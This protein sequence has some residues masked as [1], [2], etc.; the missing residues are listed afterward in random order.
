MIQPE[1]LFPLQTPPD[2]LEQT[3]ARRHFRLLTKLA[4]QEG[5]NPPGAALSGNEDGSVDVNVV[6]PGDGFILEWGID[7]W[8][9]EHRLNRDG[10]LV[11]VSLAFGGDMLQVIWTAEGGWEAVLKTSGES[12]FAVQVAALAQAFNI[13]ATASLPQQLMQQEAE[14]YAERM[15]RYYLANRPRS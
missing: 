6:L 13:K 15:F 11:G 12:T 4:R 10:P 8:E 3:L 14:V 9:V 5:I 2:N 7:Q 1:S